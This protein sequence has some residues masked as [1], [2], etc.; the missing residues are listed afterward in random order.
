MSFQSWAF[1]N[2]KV[3][4]SFNDCSSAASFG[5]GDAE[6]WARRASTVT[7]PGAGGSV[8]VEEEV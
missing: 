7:T 1:C 8:L 5:S 2:D 3:L 4:R 6:W